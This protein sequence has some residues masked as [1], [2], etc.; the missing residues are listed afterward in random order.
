MLFR[1]IL[2]EA[3]S[4]VDVSIQAQILNL[5]RDLQEKM[6]LTYLFITHDLSIVRYMSHEI[7]VLYKG[8]I[9][10][11]GSRQELFASPRHPYTLTLM[12]SIP[13]PFKTSRGGPVTFAIDE[14]IAENDRGCNFRSR[15]NRF[16][17][18]NECLTIDPK[19][20]NHGLMKIAC[21]FPDAAKARLDSDAL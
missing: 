2:D 13:D 17:G 16:H 9:V 18:Q 6:G 7:A 20:G 5:L 21:H 11:L 19:L 4:A 3:V 15:C 12:N 10:E 8:R 14:E 1:S